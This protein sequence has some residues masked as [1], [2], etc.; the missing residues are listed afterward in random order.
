M[1]SFEQNQRK[2][3]AWIAAAI[4][5]A[6]GIWQGLRLVGEGMAARSGNAITI[7]GQAKTSATAEIG[8]AH[9]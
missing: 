5:L 8:R 7:T 9:V 3:I 6:A 2:L 1:D 4:I